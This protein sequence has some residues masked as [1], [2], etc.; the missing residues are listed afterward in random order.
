MVLQAL[1]P[2]IHE[3]DVG[4]D[5]PTVEIGEERRANLAVANRAS[6]DHD[7][8]EVSGKARA[9]VD[10]GHDRAALEREQ[11]AD[12]GMAHQQ[13]GDLREDVRALVV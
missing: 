12:R 13:L 10:Q 9:P 2:R 4:D 3:A 7:G 6:G 11:L 8:V 1:P 5:P